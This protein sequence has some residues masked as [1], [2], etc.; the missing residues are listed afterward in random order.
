MIDLVIRGALVDDAVVVKKP[1]E[2]WKE[3]V[4]KTNASPH[5][6]LVSEVARAP[7]RQHG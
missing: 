6:I 1:K 2:L 7:G 4:W 3:E 5:K